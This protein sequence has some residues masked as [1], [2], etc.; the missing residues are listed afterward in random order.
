MNIKRF[1]CFLLAFVMMV[2]LFAGCA[3]QGGE[4]QT[5]TEPQSTQTPTEPV[6]VGP[7]RTAEDFIARLSDAMQAGDLPIDLVPEW[8]D[9]YSQDTKYAGYSVRLINI[10]GNYD[11]LRIVLY[12]SKTGSE[13]LSNIQIICYDEATGQ[14]REVYALLCGIASALCDEAMTEEMAAELFSAEPAQSLFATYSGDI[15]SFIDMSAITYPEGVESYESSVVFRQP[16]KLTHSILTQHIT[17]QNKTRDVM[18]Y[19]ITFAGTEETFFADKIVDFSGAPS[20]EELEQRINDALAAKGVPIT[21]TFVPYVHYGCWRGIFQWTTLEDPDYAYPEFPYEQY[22]EWG[23]SL[24]YLT[25]EVVAAYI[26]SFFRGVYLY[27]YTRDPI[28]ED[29][30]AYDIR[31]NECMPPELLEALCIAC[32]P[33]NRAGDVEV[34]HSLPIAESEGQRERVLQKDGYTITHDINEEGLQDSY[35]I[36]Y[37]ADQQW[38]TPNLTGEAL[39]DPALMDYEFRISKPMVVDGMF[40]YYGEGQGYQTYFHDSQEG[41]MSLHDILNDF[42]E[43][44]RSKFFLDPYWDRNGEHAY[45][46]DAYSGAPWDSSVFRIDVFDMVVD[47]CYDADIQD[48]TGFSELEPEE[49][50]RIPIGLSLL[51]DENLTVEE[52]IRLHT[53]AIEYDFIATA[54]DKNIAPVGYQVTVYGTGDVV[55][56]LAVNPDT[57]EN[58]YSAMT[59]MYMENA[60]SGGKLVYAHLAQYLDD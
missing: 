17:F 55:H 54:E 45:I 3:K 32:D 4:P 37:E 18:T 11:A 30:P 57:G 28:R 24:E 44:T 41:W 39:L 33:E 53:H 59:R 60:M 13:T 42:L 22:I 8:D 46:C 35:R 50:L 20:V 5:V 36:Y 34:L 27:V 52:A 40:N 31:L 29:V 47:L 26:S 12:Y 21:C 19:E 48:Y 43:Y 16:G 49:F 1:S 6:V 25:D 14:Q 7:T 2:S 38:Y 15:G 56:I 9:D 58:T 10:N 23:N 51:L